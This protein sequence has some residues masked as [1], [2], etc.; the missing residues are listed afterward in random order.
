[1]LNNSEIR[2]IVCCECGNEFEM[3]MEYLDSMEQ[4]M[5]DDEIC[6]NCFHD[7]YAYCELCEEWELIDDMTSIEKCGN[8]E[9]ILICEHCLDTDSNI[10]YCDYHERY[11]YDDYEDSIYVEDYGRICQNA[12]EWSGDFCWCEGCDNCFHIDD[13]HWDE[14]DECSYCDNCYD[15]YCGNRVIGNYHNNKDDYEYSK[16]MT[17][18]EREEGGERTFFGMEI[19]VEGVEYRG[20]GYKDKNEVATE[21]N[22]L[23]NSFVYENDGSLN[24]GFEMISYPFTKAYMDNKMENQLKHMIRVLKDNGYGVKESCG[25]HFHITRR[26]AKQVTNLVCLIEYF[27]KEIMEL[28]K[29]EENKLNRWAKFYTQGI[30]QSSLT[31]ALIQNNIDRDR[32][33]AVNLNNRNTVEFRFFNGTV[34]HT[35]LMARFEMV[36]NI[37]EY[38]MENEINDSLDNMPN[39]L[40]LVTYKSDKYVSSYLV[41]E[42]PKLVEK[43]VAK[44]VDKN[45][46][47]N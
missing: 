30:S 40:D 47:T 14:D 39:F 33:H 38:A 13:I 17:Q 11:E 41:S 46:A 19:E 9:T 2:T 18:E 8:N 43:Q 42:F 15:E 37:N 23:N 12:Y 26:N 3:D 4:L 1:M 36:Y 20:W 29:R 44:V 25:L 27:R 5:V 22:D 31:K 45:L 35:E 34:D 24:Y 16:L 6:E 28:S 10:F 32:Y 21:L 7:K